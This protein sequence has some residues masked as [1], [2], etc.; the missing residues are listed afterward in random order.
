MHRSINFILKK[1]L[2]STKTSLISCQ[3]N[4]VNAVIAD[5][6][7]DYRMSFV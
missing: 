2:K 1:G 5:L 3:S 4:E 7:D 6:N